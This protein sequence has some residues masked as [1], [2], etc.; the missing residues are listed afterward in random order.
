MIGWS[1]GKF[2]PFE[3]PLEF[4][5]WLPDWLVSMGF[6]RDFGFPVGLSVTWRGTTIPNGWYREDGT[7][8]SIASNQRL[9]QA[10]G[11]AYNTGGEPAGTFRLPNTAPGSFTI[12]KA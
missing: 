9:Y 6:R 1:R 12:I 3:V 2:S 10:I 4:K 5:A 11:T 8:I 7:T